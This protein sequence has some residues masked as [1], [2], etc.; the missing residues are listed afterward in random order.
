[1]NQLIKYLIIPMLIIILCIFYTALISIS[2]CFAFII[3]F[4]WDFK[5][6]KFIDWLTNP[7]INIKKESNITNPIK[8][9]KCIFKEIRE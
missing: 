6:L 8:L 4:L 2:Y 9:F 1:M 7:Y 5:Q 3:M